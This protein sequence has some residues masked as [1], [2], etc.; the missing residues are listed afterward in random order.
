MAKRRSFRLLRKL[1]LR[2]ILLGNMLRLVVLSF[3][4][5]LSFGLTGILLGASYAFAIQ[6]DLF[7]LRKVT[8]EDGKPLPNEVAYHF[9]GLRVGQRLF[10]VDLAKSE[11]LIRLKHPE[12]QWVLVER[13]LPDEVRIVLKEKK[14][15][16]QIHHRRYYLMDHESMIISEPSDEALEDLPVVRGIEV[17]EKKLMRGARLKS[18][19]LQQAVQLLKDIRRFKIL[20]G[21]ELT[22]IDVGDSNNFFFWIDD[23]IEV[24]ISARDFASQLKKFSDA[25][26][27]MEIDPKKIRYIDLRFDDIV[28]GPR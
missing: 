28:I 27:H 13:V 21:H 16:A 23:G 1:N 7:T 11:R 19:R 3:P 22:L 24:R 10:G 9:A 2:K 25:V 14:P 15:V 5:L 8:L 26:A 17:S 4:Y 18:H 12:Y 20:R 6:S